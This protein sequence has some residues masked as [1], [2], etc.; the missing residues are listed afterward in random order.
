MSRYVKYREQTA[1]SECK[2]CPYQRCGPCYTQVVD[3]DGN[4]PHPSNPPNKKRE[5]RCLN[6]NV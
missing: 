5:H 1:V 2:A 4:Y 3:A 6:A